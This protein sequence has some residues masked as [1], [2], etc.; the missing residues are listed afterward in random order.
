MCLICICTGF[1]LSPPPPSSIAV[2][3]SPFS[4]PSY[5]RGRKNKKQNTPQQQRTKQTKHK[6]TNNN[7]TNK[8]EVNEM[9]VFIISSFYVRLVNQ[10]DVCAVIYVRPGPYLYKYFCF[11]HGPAVVLF[12]YC[13][14]YGEE[15]EKKNLL[16]FKPNEKKKEKKKKKKK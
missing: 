2:E 15:K 10:I 13:Y 9:N 12:M 4:H 8:N 3:F 6:T 14:R 1:F 11:L 5:S 16:L 7:N